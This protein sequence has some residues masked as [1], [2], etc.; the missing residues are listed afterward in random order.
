MNAFPTTGQRATT[1]VVLTLLLTAC[2]GASG[3]LTHA[4][5]VRRANAIC[6]D[7]TRKIVRIPRG[8]ST[9]LNA[10]GYLGAVLSVA[11]QGLK[12][13]HALRPP[14]ADEPLY[15]SFLREL[16]RNTNDLRTLRAA[17][18]A[19]DRKD[20]VIGVADL[21][22]SRVRINNLERRLGLNRCASG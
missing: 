4:E 18:A 6:V 11:E 20:Y 3:R 19:R 8:P 9:A 7:Q 21:H 1:L 22:G 16:D 5:L 13:F 12:Q 10:A 2:G 17:A 14:K 15:G